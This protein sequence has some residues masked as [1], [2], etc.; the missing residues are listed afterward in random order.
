MK[1]THKMIKSL[2][3]TIQTKKNLQKKDNISYANA[4]RN[5]EAG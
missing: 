5:S 2:P 1:Y 3:K 4:S